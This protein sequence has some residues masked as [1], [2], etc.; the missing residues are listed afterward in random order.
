MKWFVRLMAMI[1]MVS[2]F[3]LLI[4]VIFS[5]KLTSNKK[6]N[7]AHIK[8]SGTLTSFEDSGKIFKRY[9]QLSSGQIIKIFENISAKKDIKGILL[10]INSP[11]GTP[12]A[13]EEIARAVKECPL[14]VVA[15][16]REVGASGAYWVAMASDHIVAHPLSITGSIGVLANNFGLEEI[17]E[18]FQIKYRRM[19]AGE[20]KDIGTPFRP[21]TEKE[22][23]YLQD[24]LNQVHEEFI[25][26]FT[27]YRKLEPAKARELANGLFYT[28]RN[29]LANKMID[30][31]G[32]KSEALAWLEKKIKE[33]V[34]LLQTG[35]G[36]SFFNSLLQGMQESC[37]NII[38]GNYFLKALVQNK[39]NQGSLVEL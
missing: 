22:K 28:G 24:L 2:C 10:E 35:Q 39:T 19:V 6:S 12:V 5:Q 13:S 26:A 3:L 36:F 16:I 7:V 9:G 23:A 15:W 8:L 30:Q 31:L 37:S 34:V 21:Q 1:G 25:Q 32:G 14:P 29:A 33:P 38:T 11:G 17:L 18:K 4:G 20:F 27:S